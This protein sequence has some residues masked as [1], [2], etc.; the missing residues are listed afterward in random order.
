MSIAHIVDQDAILEADEI[1]YYGKDQHVEAIG[2]IKIT[3]GDKIIFSS[4]PI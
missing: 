2:N 3:R 1:I 4:D